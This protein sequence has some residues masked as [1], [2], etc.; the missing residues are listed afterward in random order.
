MYT[1]YKWLNVRLLKIK[2]EMYEKKCNLGRIAKR[3]TVCVFR[4]EYEADYVVME[5]LYN[6]AAETVCNLKTCDRL[7]TPRSIVIIKMINYND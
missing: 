6:A 2:I 3:D 7:F 5:V 1:T 4:L